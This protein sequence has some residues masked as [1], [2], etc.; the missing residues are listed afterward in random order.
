MQRVQSFQ[1]VGLGAFPKSPIDRMSDERSATYVDIHIGARM[2]LL[3]T[4]L[5]ISQERFAEMLG[6]TYQQV[7]KYERG[8]NRLAA[9]RL[10]LASKVLN[11]GVSYFF[12]G[13]D[14]D[15][16]APTESVLRPPVFDLIGTP[17]GVQLA[18]AYA[19]IASAETR[20]SL[21]QLV[22]SLSA[23]EI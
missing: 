19:S 1:E 6:V 18:A 15:K 11:V 4:T 20:Q 23:G 14:C 3:R 9:S 17:D 22:M 8:S 2:R 12:D 10:W 16:P 7:Q 5:S 21:L 13:L